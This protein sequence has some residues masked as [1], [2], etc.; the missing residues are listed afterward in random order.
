MCSPLCFPV[1]RNA[2]KGSSDSAATGAPAI[3]WVRQCLTAE[4]RR[5]PQKPEE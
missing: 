3:Y 4:T 1:A 5:N 2:L